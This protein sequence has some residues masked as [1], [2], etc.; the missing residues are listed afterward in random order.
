MAILGIDLG[1]SSVKVIILDTHGHTLSMS[2]ASYTVAAPQA[3]WS[4]SDPN[5][6]WSATI[7]AVQAVRAQAP[8]ARITA[9]GLSGQMHG[10]VL[11]DE[12]GQSVRPAMLWADT[13]AQEELTRYRTLPA[14]L[15]EQLA[16]PLVPGM[17]GPLLLWLAKHEASSY[18]RA[19]WALQ[20]K[21][22]LRF[23]L[24][25]EAATDPS[26]ASAT[27]LYDLYADT[28]TDDVIVALSLKRSLLPPIIPSGA[29]A[30]HLSMK[31]AEALN[32]P[33]GLA[34]A[35]GAADTAA[36]ALG[37]GLLAPGPI[38][39]TLGTGA[40]LIQIC[41]TPTVGPEMRTHLYRAADSSNWYAMAAVQN[42][43]LA[44]DWVRAMLNASWDD[45]YASAGT[46]A[47][48]V[49]GP[50]FLPY[51]TV[52]RPYHPGL[53]NNGAFLGLRIDQRRDQ[54]LHAALTGVASGIR[55]AFE[56]LP[57]AHETTSLRLAGGGSEHP[58][59]R[60]MLADILNQE[61]HSVDTPAASARG[62][63]LLGGIAGG[64]WANAQ[65]T[66]SIAP[67]TS[68]IATPDARRV[69]MYNRIYT[70]YLE[71]IDG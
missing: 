60:Q 51:L 21:D 67:T 11:T 32:L 38:Q 70:R 20:P 25:D 23:C 3:G 44:L 5:A 43:G 55:V 46:V 13:R 61:L 68:L 29:V 56:A 40:Q 63:A 64:I 34:V 28:W 41:A 71:A 69:E 14:S 48:D 30:G 47:P 10:V 9:I 66:A 1:T 45:L 59:W 2:K 50:L 6:W 17:A 33:V 27:L 42:A 39:L 31:A 65:E 53:P 22:W 52:E 54:L 57:S 37:T 7:S 4:E 26:D 8:Q 19:R 15:L 36:A 16:N 62:A 12:K 18:D 24:T 35:T 49:E 58:A